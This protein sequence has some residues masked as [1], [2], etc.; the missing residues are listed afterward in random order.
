MTQD[1]TELVVRLL[2][3]CRVIVNLLLYV[4][5]LHA[6]PAGDNDLFQPDVNR[7][8]HHLVI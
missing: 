4:R 1:G 5:V 8:Q 3:N 2:R 6:V 7:F